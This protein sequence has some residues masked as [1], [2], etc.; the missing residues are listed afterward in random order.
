MILYD[1]ICTEWN[2]PPFFLRGGIS[3]G[4]FLFIHSGDKMWIVQ[5]V[6]A[7]VEPRFKTV[8]LLQD[9]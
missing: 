4:Y 9:D 7:K 6:C 2:E 1:P 5:E 3:C 8:D